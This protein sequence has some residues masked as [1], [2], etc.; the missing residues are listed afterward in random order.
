MDCLKD[1]ILDSGRT[2][3]GSGKGAAP[4]S[5]RLRGSVG[6]YAQENATFRALYRVILGASTLIR[7]SLYCIVDDQD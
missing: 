2:W 5:V 7:R 1:G 4:D 6:G 3:V